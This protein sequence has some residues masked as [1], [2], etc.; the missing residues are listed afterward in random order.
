MFLKLILAQVYGMSS[1]FPD[2]PRLLNRAWRIV[3]LFPFLMASC[4]SGGGSSD[5]G[6]SD[7]ANSPIVGSWITPC[8]SSSG[9]LSLT[10]AI[11]FL[12][13]GKFTKT[14]S[15][16]F[17][18]TCSIAAFDTKTTGTVEESFSYVLPD[19]GTVSNINFVTKT[20]SII[21]RSDDSVLF[22]NTQA[23]CEIS[24]WE[25]GV[26]YDISSCSNRPGDDVSRRPT[27]YADYSIYLVERGQLFYGN[28]ISFTAE[29]RPTTLS[30]RPAYIRSSGVVGDEFPLEL[31]GLWIFPESDQYVELSGQGLIRFY[32]RTE[33][34]C[35]GF[36]FLTLFSDG[37]GQ[38]HDPFRIFTYI[39]GES[40]GNLLLSFGTNPEVFTY[41]PSTISVEQLDLC[42]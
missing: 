13:N 31:K 42:A 8:D 15:G 29:N 28:E 32:G 11:E 12:T 41:M 16:Y 22:F 1:R 37:G 27:P 40:E 20:Y 21:P 14:V 9:S 26:D 33:Q 2:L 39:I 3:V 36:N 5:T 19:R 6:S 34:G 7:L 17:D 10:T 35:F 38:Y 25:V 4:S 23:T 30:T 18:L 24:D